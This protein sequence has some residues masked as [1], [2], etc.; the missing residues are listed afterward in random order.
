MRFMGYIVD[1]YILGILNSLVSRYIMKVVGGG[2]RIGYVFKDIFWNVNMFLMVIFMYMSFMN[3][4]GF[5]FLMYVY[6]MFFIGYGMYFVRDGLLFFFLYGR[7]FDKN[8]CMVCECLYVNF[9]WG[10]CDL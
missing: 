5:F 4:M 2:G 1:L 6:G 8:S 3:S 10:G 9:K 7:W